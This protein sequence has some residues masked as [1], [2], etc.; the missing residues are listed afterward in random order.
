MQ[1]AAALFAD[2]SDHH[3][4]SGNKWC[5]RI[6][7]PLIM[8]SLFGMLSLLAIPLGRVPADAALL[9]IALGSIYYFAL[10]LRY[11][12][13]MLVF[14]ITLY[15]IG[16][17]VPFTINMILFV[18][19]WILQF[20]GHGVFEKRSPAFLR[21]LVHLLVGPIWIVNDVIPL[22]SSRAEEVEG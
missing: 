20:V 19:G 8:L 10:G 9:L 6:G 17:R 2:Y 14:S 11:G 21:N 15:L 22:A 12:L 1:S 13:A 4:T 5:H 7:I 16:S 18:A 3:R